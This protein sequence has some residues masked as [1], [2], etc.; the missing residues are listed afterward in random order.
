MANPNKTVAR[1]MAKRGRDPRV[2]EATAKRMAET[3]F[4][5]DMAAW[6][7]GE[8]TAEEFQRRHD[9]AFKPA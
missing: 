7:R 6:Q 8:M 4:F 2:A 5:K 1:F 9:P 3:D